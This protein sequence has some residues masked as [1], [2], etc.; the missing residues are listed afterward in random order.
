MLDPEQN[1]TFSDH[2]IEVAFDLSRVMFIATANTLATIPP[3]LLDRM[4]V[5]ELPGYTERDKRAIARDHLVPKQLE[6]H[7]LSPQRVTVTDDAIDKVVREYTREA[8][9]RNLDRSIA[10][11]VRKAARRVA[12]A[13][14]ARVR[15]GD[16]RRLR[17]ARRSGPPPH[18]PET[19]ERTTL[20]GVVVGLAHTSHGGDIL[21]IEATVLPG[22]EGRAP[23]PHGPA[24]R[25]DA[26]V[27]PRPRSPGCARTRTRSVCRRSRSRPPRS[28]STCRPAPCRRT[29]RRRASRWRPRWSPRSRVAARAASVAMTGE[30]SLRG[31][32]LPVGGIKDKVLAASRAGIQTVVLPRRNEKDLVDVGPEIREKLEIRLVDTIEE[33]LAIAL[34]P[35]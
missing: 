29:A 34:E 26:R 23:A 19:A 11:L 21:F 10:T 27:A 33:V 14:R 20:P 8:G 17:R 3:A 4:E 30:I 13:R 5:I 35:A 15:A 28:I 18:L 7:G 12:D 25:R 22:G 9:V 16:R 32:V 31:R 24:R 2:Y 6:A 1:A